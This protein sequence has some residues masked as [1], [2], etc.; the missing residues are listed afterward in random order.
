[1][2]LS[3]SEGDIPL[4]PS[5]QRRSPVRAHPGTTTSIPAWQ[6]MFYQQQAPPPNRLASM[7]QGFLMAMGTVFLMTIA[8]VL[9]LYWFLGIAPNDMAGLAPTT[10]GS[11]SVS[12]PRI[13][14]IEQPVAGS[15]QRAPVEQP[16]AVQQPPTVQ[17]PVVE[18]PLRTAL[19]TAGK[20]NV[21]RA[22]GPDK[23]LVNQ[24]FAG[25]SVE[26]LEET[27]LSDGVLWVR[28]RALQGRAT[29]VQGW[30]NARFLK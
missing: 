21:R 6:P 16:P 5:Q 18:T 25:E 12:R 14:P 1:M 24:L 20:L 9:A 22:A 11:A 15:E 19:V 3:S 28:I 27:R 4:L 8:A 2:D 13:A 29:P 10:A 17:D 30:V 26:V 23:E 7:V